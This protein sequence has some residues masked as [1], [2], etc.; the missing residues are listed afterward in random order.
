MK[1]LHLNLKSKYW[2]EIKAGE[3]DWE[4]RLMTPYWLKRLVN[5]NYDAICIKKGYPKGD[6]YSRMIWKVFNGYKLITLNHPEFGEDDK[7]VFA[8]DVREDL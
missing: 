2:D 1:V 4:Y 5:I 3:K 7:K 8:I 6:D